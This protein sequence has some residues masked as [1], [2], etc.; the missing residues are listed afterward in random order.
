MVVVAVDVGVCVSRAVKARG[1]GVWSA[2]RGA[3]GHGSAP[4]RAQI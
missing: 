1:Q 2:F 4:M 3:F